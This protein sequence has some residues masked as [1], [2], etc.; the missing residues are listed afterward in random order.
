MRSRSTLLYK[1]A[2]LVM[3][4]VLIVPI[5]A[6]CGDDDEEETATPVATTPAKTTPA[7]TTPAATTPAPTVSKEP[8]KI[9]VMLPYSGQGAV[10]STIAEMGMKVVK[11]ELAEKGGINVG[12]V[13]RPI[14]WVTCDTKTQVAEC[15]VCFNKLALQEKVSA[16]IYGGA[17]GAEFIADVD[18]AQEAKVPFFSMGASPKDLSTYPYTIRAIYP[19]AID[20]SK[21]TA[22]FVVSNFKPKTVALLGLDDQNVRE[23]QSAVKAILTAAGIKVVYEQYAAAGSLD[24]SPFLTRIRMENPDVLVADLSGGDSYTAI[25]KQMPELGGWGNIKVICPT[26]SSSSANS[27]KQTGAEGSYHWL[28]WMAGS[29]TPESV[30]FEQVF[31]AENGRAPAASD[32]MMYGPPEVAL[33]TI[34]LAGSDKPEDIQKAMRSGKVVWNSPAGLLTIYADG[35]PSLAG[36]IVQ[37]T[38]GKLVPV[39]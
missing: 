25:F 17:T 18:F 9:G 10:A 4:L 8:I 1:L 39:K 6:A 23:R 5:L 32:F 20:A 33:R 21:M 28:M 11:K 26:A 16:I 27:L 2:A 30:K 29:G 7:A 24:Y 35:S 3:V 19:A 15:K 37:F 36:Q 13:I 12:G 14:E 34:E 31:A 22:E 38:G